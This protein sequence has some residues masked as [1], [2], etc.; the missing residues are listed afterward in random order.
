[1]VVAGLVAVTA[2]VVAV[3]M[4]LSVMVVAPVV[5]VLALVALA[6]V[7]LL[8]VPGRVIGAA[9]GQRRAGAADR[10]D[11]GGGRR[12]GSLQHSVPPLSDEWDA[13]MS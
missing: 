8:V 11:Q 6:V 4:V 12:C 2:V 3:A 5:M 10:Q 9:R 13:A 1:M 7:V